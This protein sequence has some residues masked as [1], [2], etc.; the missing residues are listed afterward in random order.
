[1]DKEASSEKRSYELRPGWQEA[2][3]DYQ[4]EGDSSPHV[5]ERAMYEQ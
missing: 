4:G 1:M 5:G 3:K 2:S